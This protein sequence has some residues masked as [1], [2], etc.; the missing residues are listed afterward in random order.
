VVMA[1]ESSCGD[2]NWPMGV[3]AFVRIITGI[4]L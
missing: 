2:D 1:A 4:C 3:D